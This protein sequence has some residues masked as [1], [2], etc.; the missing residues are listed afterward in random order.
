MHTCSDTPEGLK[1]IYIR[2][3]AVKTMQIL[4]ELK[5]KLF[6]WSQSRTE[7]KTMA[8][9]PRGKGDG[10]ILVSLWLLVSITEK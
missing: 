4:N 10:R 8:L 6:T 7:T 3:L 1:R 5:R 9:L 2:K